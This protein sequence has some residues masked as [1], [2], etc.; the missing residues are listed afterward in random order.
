MPAITIYESPNVTVW[1]HTDKRV[2]HHQIRKFVH[3]AEFQA[4]LTAGTE[5]LTKYGAVKWLSDD[6][7][8]TV[9]SQEDQKWG[10][11]VWFPQTAKAGWKYWAIVRPEKV[12]ARL[13]MEKLTR[14]YAA[15]GVTA[16]FFNNPDDA[17]RWLESQ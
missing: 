6:R 4:F 10:H 5:A 12:L 3:G 15:A 13:T 14:E 11:D 2:V 9:L 17:M 8:N 16:K 1:Y 7:G